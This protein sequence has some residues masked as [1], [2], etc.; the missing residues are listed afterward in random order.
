[1][2]RQFLIVAVGGAA[3]SMLRFALGL[4][5]R[6]LKNT[7]WPWGTLAANLVGCFIIGF[8]FALTIKQ[9]GI[10]E[11][12]QL[13]LAT[14]FCGGLTTFSTFT[15]ENFQM[16]KQGNWIGFIS[17]TLLS[18]LAGLGAVVLGWQLVK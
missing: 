4:W 8:L 3:G 13:L 10:S 18:L 1:M 9:K 7:W 6:S 16:L 11:N 2:M 12:I 14:G 15:F 5:S 17:Y